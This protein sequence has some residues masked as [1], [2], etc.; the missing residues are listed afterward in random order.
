MTI[1]SHHEVYFSTEIKLT[2]VQS[3]ERHL[4]ITFSLTKKK[5]QVYLFIYLSIYLKTVTFFH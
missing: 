4:Y 3:K 5:E 1:P 2:N